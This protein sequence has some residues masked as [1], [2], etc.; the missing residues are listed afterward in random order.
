MERALSKGGAY[1]INWIEDFVTAADL[2]GREGNVNCDSRGYYIENCII[3]FSWFYIKI[4][5]L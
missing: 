4:T 2:M 3:T 5:N 1:T